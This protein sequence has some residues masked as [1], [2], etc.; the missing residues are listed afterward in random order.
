ME[1][2]K[3]YTNS[4]RKRARKNKIMVNMS[5]YGLEHEHAIEQRSTERALCRVSSTKYY[6]WKRKQK[7]RIKKKK[8]K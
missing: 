4:A 3:R 6:T 8:T 2:D 1:R 7:E 5:V